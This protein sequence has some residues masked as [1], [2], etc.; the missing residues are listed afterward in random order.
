MKTVENEADQTEVQVITSLSYA[1]NQIFTA[2]V[3]DDKSMAVANFTLLKENKE[4]IF[5]AT[6]S[7]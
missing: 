4:E 5:T 1:L 2:T 6:N 7:V 3:C